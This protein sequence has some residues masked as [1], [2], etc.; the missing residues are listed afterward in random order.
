[1]G[2]SSEG[3]CSPV[4]R[5][6][7][8]LYNIIHKKQPKVGIPTK[9]KYYMSGKATKIPKIESTLYGRRQGTV[10][11]TCLLEKRIYIQYLKGIS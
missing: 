3:H 9:R 8:V 7:G 10:M 11:D 6:W 2:F 4:N 1:M 5:S